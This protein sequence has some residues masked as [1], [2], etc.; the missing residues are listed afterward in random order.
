[1]SSDLRQKQRAVTPETA[2]KLHADFSSD[3]GGLSTD[4]SYGLLLRVRL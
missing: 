4:T 2:R 3:Y 1:M